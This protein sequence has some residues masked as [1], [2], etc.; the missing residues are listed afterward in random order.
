[1]SFIDKKIKKIE[2]I[3]NNKKTRILKIIKKGKSKMKKHEIKEIL[4]R[5][6]ARFKDK[7][8]KFII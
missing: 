4:T 6:F 7:I 1:L 5:F 8:N 2:K 3:R